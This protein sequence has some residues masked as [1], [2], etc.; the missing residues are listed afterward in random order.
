M[1]THKPGG[2]S[3][4]Y[5][6][7]VKALCAEAHATQG[8]GDGRESRR[9]ANYGDSTALFPNSSHHASWLILLGA[10]PGEVGSFKTFTKS[11]IL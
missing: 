7:K 3:D 9:H 10:G 4:M 6:A 1:M 11:R 8:L 5:L 2:D